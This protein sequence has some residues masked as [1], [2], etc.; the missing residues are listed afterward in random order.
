M[1]CAKP[2]GRFILGASHSIA[3]GTKYDNFMA[4]LDEY[5]KLCQ[6]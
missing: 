6:Y 3:V 1:A 5:T 4:M 2:G